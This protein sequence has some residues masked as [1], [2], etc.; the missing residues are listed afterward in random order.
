MAINTSLRW[1]DVPGS[2]I[3]IRVGVGVA[4]CCFGPFLSVIIQSR[5]FRFWGKY[6]RHRFPC[7]LLNSGA[8][9]CCIYSD[10]K[11]FMETTSI[12][13]KTTLPCSSSCLCADGLLIATE[14][15]QTSVVSKHYTAHLAFKN[16]LLGTIRTTRTVCEFIYFVMITSRHPV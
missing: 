16:T 10:A 13:S 8:S 3:L 6:C 9:F 15:L 2:G 1:T 12:L 4:V 7:Y 14:Y 11:C 5:E